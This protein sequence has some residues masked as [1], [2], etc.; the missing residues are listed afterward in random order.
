MDNS[1]FLILIGK[2]EILL[3]KK[4]MSR[5]KFN[6]SSE[7][8]TKC[9]LKCFLFYVGC[10]CLILLFCEPSIMRSV[11][12]LICYN[13]FPL[14]NL[15]GFFVIHC[16]Y[17]IGIFVKRLTYKILLSGKT[18]RAYPTKLLS[19]KK[20]FWQPLLSNKDMHNFVV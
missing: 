15:R 10:I 16:R 4:E 14:E 7:S 9:C 5:E 17:V 12:C 11:C 20:C 1:K 6:R 18:W 19:W 13:V 8:H 2:K 3:G